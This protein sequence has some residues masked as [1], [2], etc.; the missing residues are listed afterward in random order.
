MVEGSLDG[1]IKSLK[2]LWVTC[3]SNASVSMM[4]TSTHGGEEDVASLGQSTISRRDTAVTVMK[5]S[6]CHF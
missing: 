1:Q 2:S 6:G 4:D 5:Q 3:I